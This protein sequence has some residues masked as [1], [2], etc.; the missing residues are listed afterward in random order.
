MLNLILRH[1][2]ASALVLLDELD[3]TSHRTSN[4][5]PVTSALLGLLEPESARR[6]HDTFLQTSC[7]LSKLCFWATANGLAGI[8]K[9]LLSRFTLIYM[10]APRKEHMHVLVHGIV[11]DITK[12]W[13]LPS[14]VL[15]LPPHEVYEG[16]PLN[17]RE[18]RRLVT[19]FLCAWGLEHRRPD[20]MH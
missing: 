9:P 3:K 13:G 5:T 2:S 10:P 7:D 1:K 6:W 11:D 17:A 15:P 14:D 12:A 19:Q 20:Q 8:P 4:S 16:V 18:L